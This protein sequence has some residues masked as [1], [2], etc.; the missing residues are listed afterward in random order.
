ML[1]LGRFSVILMT[2]TTDGRGLHT[3]VDFRCFDRPD[4][5]AIGSC[6]TVLPTHLSLF[7]KQAYRVALQRLWDFICIYFGLKA[8]GLIYMNWSSVF[9]ERDQVNARGGRVDE[10]MEMDLWR[11]PLSSSSPARAT[12]NPRGR[13]VLISKLDGGLHRFHLTERGPDAN[14]ERG[15]CEPVLRFPLQMKLG[16]AC[17]IFSCSPADCAAFCRY[18]RHK[19]HGCTGV[20]YGQ[21]NAGRSPAGTA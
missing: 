7:K 19:T 1:H 12:G 3:F 18:A 11:Y 14:F 8:C 2:T 5:S 9:K 15:R 10:R 4:K 6:F 17:A 16:S 21:A 13:P 20:A